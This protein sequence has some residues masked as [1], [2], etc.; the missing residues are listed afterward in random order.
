MLQ[1]SKK[2]CV[3]VALTVFALFLG[4]RYWEA[5][6]GFITTALASATPIFI[7]LA[8]A[9]VLNLLMSVYES[10]FFPHSTKK[11]VI[12]MRRPL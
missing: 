10:I 12:K 5:L 2:T 7:G 4:F 11:A 9:Y 6:E 3:T 1:I 8:I